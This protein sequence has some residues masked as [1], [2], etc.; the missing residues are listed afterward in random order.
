[1]YHHAAAARQAVLRE[2]EAAEHLIA[3]AHHVDKALAHAG[4]VGRRWAAMRLAWQIEAG[5]QTDNKG[6]PKKERKREG[7]KE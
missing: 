2:L 5:S 1:M 3:R 6:E 4:E 7:A